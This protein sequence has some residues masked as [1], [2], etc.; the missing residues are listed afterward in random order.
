MKTLLIIVLL[1]VIGYL[2]VKPDSVPVITVTVDG[3][4]VT[5]VAPVP[6][7][8]VVT[9]YGQDVPAVVH[10][11]QAIDVQRVGQWV[12][13][14]VATTVPARVPLLLR[15]GP[16]PTVPPLLLRP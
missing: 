13:V 3:K 12:A 5:Q 11:E 4:T 16:T 8:R 15:P 9:P 2:L 14:P 10:T 7:V 6:A 1:L